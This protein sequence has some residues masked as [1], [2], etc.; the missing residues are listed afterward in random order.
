MN[1]GHYGS[2]FLTFFVWGFFHSILVDVIFLETLKENFADPASF[3]LGPGTVIPGIFS[4][5]FFYNNQVKNTQINICLLYT[6]DA[7]DD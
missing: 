7:A 4:S 1:L 3:F 6:S 5:A 2:G